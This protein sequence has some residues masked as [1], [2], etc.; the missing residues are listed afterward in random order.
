MS[1]DS[2]HYLLP[3]GLADVLPGAA[4]FEAA[5][6]ERVMA[7]FAAWGYDRVK[8]PL[9]EF[10]DSLLSG[11]GAVMAAH[12][13]R[14]MDPVSQRMMGLRAD[15]TPQVARIAASRLK[16][17][18][19]PLRVSYAGQVLRVKGE[20]MRPERQLGQAGIELVGATTAA[21]DAEVVLL[22][23]DALRQAGV[24]HLAV[25]LNLPTLTPTI[26][27]AAG[28]ADP[29]PLIAALDRKDVAAVRKLAGKET[30]LLESLLQTVGPAGP[31]LT[32]LAA[33]KL[34]PA[35]AA[36]RQR[37]IEVVDLIQAAAPD[38][39]LT[40][41]PT[42]HRGFEY[43]TG[44]TFSLLGRRVS[45]EF[46]RGGR[47][48]NQAG[49]EATGFTLYLNTILSALPAPTEPKRVFLPSGTT[50]T[51]AASL[52]K[53]GWVTIQDLGRANTDA[54]TEARR[55]GCQFLWNGDVVVEL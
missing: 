14:L 19:R 53:Q 46:G 24:P 17:N 39:P 22:A 8:P 9:M 31:A 54:T 7:V 21:A 16:N 44:I 36:H 49:E 42:D 29:A 40:I 3:A 52:R 51:A 55:L 6:V 13:F 2:Q 1:T 20:Q 25:D 5:M 28:F 27:A 26:L 11:P 38:L 37:L 32:K 34:P 33:V 30:A 18:P 43:H 35:A 12:T 41:D 50:A 48:V 23:V 47:Y 45:G 10:E 4:A 15:I